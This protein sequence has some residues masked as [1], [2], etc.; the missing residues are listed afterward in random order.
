MNRRGFVA[1]LVGLVVTPLA[2]LRADDDQ[3]SWLT[4][5]PPQ[6]LEE[7]ARYTVVCEHGHQ[8]E[9]W[10]DLAQPTPA[11]A[12]G[13]APLP[14]G[15]RMAAGFEFTVMPKGVRPPNGQAAMVVHPAGARVPREAMRI[16]ELT[17]DTAQGGNWK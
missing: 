12:H 14:C 15:G 7:W 5:N 3:D 17:G 8:V 11:W 1:F 2:W 10:L 6:D 16:R 13:R 4:F 9:F